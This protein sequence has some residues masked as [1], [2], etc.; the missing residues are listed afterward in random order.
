MLVKPVTLTYAWRDRPEL[1]EFG[2]R[3]RY[4]ECSGNDNQYITTDANGNPT[5]QTRLPGEAGF[6][7]PRGVD[8]NRNPDLPAGLTGQ[9]K[10]PIFNE[11]FF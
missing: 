3:I 11:S 2:F 6:S 1:E 5:T 10:S 7:D 4:F 9:E 8:P